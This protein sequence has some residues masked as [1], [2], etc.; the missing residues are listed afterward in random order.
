[1][2][3]FLICADLP[4][5]SFEHIELT[6]ALRSHSRSQLLLSQLGSASQGHP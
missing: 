6:I 1:M 4:F 5:Y 2:D 3:L